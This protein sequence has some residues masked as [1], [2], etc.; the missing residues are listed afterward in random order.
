[1]CL[2]P[3]QFATE[4]T[5]QAPESLRSPP[6][7]TAFDLQRLRGC[8]QL[9]QY[10]K[11]RSSAEAGEFYC[12]FCHPDRSKIAKEGRHSRLMWCNP[13]HDHTRHHLLIVPFNHVITP[14]DFTDEQWLEFLHFFRWA[15]AEYDIKGGGL[16]LRWGNP[17]FNAGSME[18]FHWNLQEPDGTG[19]VQITLAKE[20]EEVAASAARAARFAAVYEQL[21]REGR[22]QGYLNG[23][24]FESLPPRS[25][26]GKKDWPMGDMGATGGTAP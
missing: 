25:W 17:A 16:G 1:M 4:Y 7:L 14:D 6:K 23:V 11:T 2:P 24:D 5:S 10:C 12:P 19:R 3:C 13:P 26:D 9:E 22:R 21:E 18:H 15:L 8:R 20:P